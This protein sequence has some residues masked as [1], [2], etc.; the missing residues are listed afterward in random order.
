MRIFDKYLSNIPTGG[1]HRRRIFAG[2]LQNR[3]SEICLENIR[4]FGGKCENCFGITVMYYPPAMRVPTYDIHIISIKITGSLLATVTVGDA[5][6]QGHIGE[7]EKG[8]G[9]LCAYLQIFV[10]S[11]NPCI[12]VKIF[13]NIPPRPTSSPARRFAQAPARLAVR[14]FGDAPRV[15][16][17]TCMDHGSRIWGGIVNVPLKIEGRA[18][19]PFGQRRNA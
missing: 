1:A 7:R 10:T 17:V 6:A 13:A 18:R 5:S 11:T 3:G 9:I 15:H 12:F 14:P 2:F 8:R 4:A 19:W 16:S